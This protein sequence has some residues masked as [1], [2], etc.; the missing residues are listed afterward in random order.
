MLVKV[1][2][3]SFKN[4]DNI[5][6]EPC[7]YQISVSQQIFYDQVL[8]I[9]LFEEKAR[10]FFESVK[11]C[12]YIQ[13]R[14][15][16]S[17]FSVFEVHNPSSGWQLKIDHW[18]FCELHTTWLPC[19]QRIHQKIRNY[20][21]GDAIGSPPNTTVG[22][23]D[24]KLKLDTDEGLNTTVSASN[25]ELKTCRSKLCANLPGNI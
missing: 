2:K 1:E 12:I 22:T 14:K 16:S 7:Y 20:R 10:S 3:V 15:E 9:S 19:L 24:C 18:Y 5:V 17:V 13:H 8:L 6:N 11:R 23:S 4:A 25:R 21:Q